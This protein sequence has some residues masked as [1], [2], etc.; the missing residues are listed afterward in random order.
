MSLWK[1]DDRTTAGLVKDMYLEL[2]DENEIDVVLMNIK[3][4]YIE[5]A[6]EF[7]SHPYFWA[8]LVQVGDSR[9]VEVGAS[10]Y[11]GWII[12]A[13]LIGFLLLYALYRHYGR[14]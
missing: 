5:N 12:A 10:L 13:F 1:I 11:R 4:R 14:T 2:L 3:K 8:A 7:K 9:P 6:N